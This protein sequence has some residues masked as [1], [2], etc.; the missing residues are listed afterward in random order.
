[1]LYGLNPWCFKIFYNALFFSTV[2]ISW[3]KGHADRVSRHCPDFWRNI[4]LRLSGDFE[5]E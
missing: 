1:M 3:V 2:I 4:K 5:S